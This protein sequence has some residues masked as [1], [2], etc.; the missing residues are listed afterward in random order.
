MYACAAAGMAGNDKKERQKKDVG[1]EGM[2]SITV[3]IPAYKP[4]EKLINTLSELVQVGFCDILVVDDGSGEAFVPVFARVKE[5]PQ[6]TLLTHPVNRGKGAALKTAMKYVLENRKESRCVVTADADGQHLAEDIKAV[7]R[8]ALETGSAVLGVRDFS[9]PKVPPKSKAGNRITRAV[10][11]LC[12]GARIA[13]T[14]TGLRAFPLAYLPQ[15]AAVEGDRYEY[16][17]NM[18]IVMSR[19]QIPLEQV[20]IATVYIE[21]NRSSHFRAVRDSVRVYAFIFK[22]LLSSTLAAVVDEL[23]FLL[24]KSMN[25][26]AGLPIPLTYTASILARIISS[27]LNYFINAK[28]VFR[29]DAG[30]KS[31]VRY[32]ALAVVQLGLSATLVYGAEMLLSITAPVLSALVK[33]CIDTVLFF[34]SFRIQH[35]WV[36]Y[37]EKRKSN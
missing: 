19:Q 1:I 9:D 22:Y 28:L 37:R 26:L 35:K 24:F 32:Y 11:R 5:F 29:E 3:V 8:K 10:F 15:I 34:F 27:L 20:P 33:V 18:L 23:G 17:T 2:K 14:Q 4:D 7:A 6:C 12:F 36:F 21:E 13:D 25:L 31:L 16:E 30:G